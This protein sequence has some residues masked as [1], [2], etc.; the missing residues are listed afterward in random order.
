M[1]LCHILSAK[2]FKGEK[3]VLTP[4]P[5]TQTLKNLILTPS[6][7][8]LGCLCLSAKWKFWMIFKTKVIINFL[9]SLLI[10]VNLYIF[11]IMALKLINIHWIRTDAINNYYCLLWSGIPL[12]W[13]SSL[14][15]KV[16]HI[17]MDF[18]LDLSF[19][20]ILYYF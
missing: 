4:S 15:R 3:G 13:L 19:W 16:L 1:E 7:K 5:Q 8:M 14:F 6:N 11:S 17:Y 9:R 18:F 2:M 20:I 10:L 12:R